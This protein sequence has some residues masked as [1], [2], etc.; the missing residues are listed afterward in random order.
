MKPTGKVGSRGVRQFGRPAIRSAVPVSHSVARIPHLASPILRLAS[1]ILPLRT[2]NRTLLAFLL[3]LS[4]LPACRT[5]RPP[6]YPR[7]VPSATRAEAALPASMIRVG[8]VETADPVEVQCPRGCTVRQGPSEIRRLANGGTLRVVPILQDSNGAPSGVWVQVAALQDPS[9][10]EALRD[11]LRQ[12]FPD[13]PA[14]HVQAFQDRR[15]V[16]AGPWADEAAA[17]AFLRRLQAAGYEA[18]LD[19]GNAESGRPTPSAFQL[20]V[21]SWVTTVPADRPL[22]VIADS[23]LTWRGQRYPGTLRV[24]ALPDG[25]VALVNVLPLELYLVGVLVQELNPQKFPALEA[26]KAQAVAARTYAVRNRN[27]Y[28][29][30]GYDICA[31]PACQAYAGVPEP[32]QA[33][34]AYTAVAETRGEVLT[35]GGEP[36]QAFYTSTCGGHTDSAEFIFPRFAA[37]YLQGVPCPDD[38]GAAAQTVEGAPMADLWASPS[39]ARGFV[40]WVHEARIW[41]VDGTLPETDRWDRWAGVW[42]DFLR[43]GLSGG[44]A[45]ASAGANPSHRN[46]PPLKPPPTRRQLLQALGRQ[47]QDPR[48][49]DLLL[50]DDT[51][52]LDRLAQGLRGDLDG[53]FRRGLLWLLLMAPDLAARWLDGGVDWPRPVRFDEWLYV[54]GRWRSAQAPPDVSEAV[55]LGVEAG[56]LRLQDP[57]GRL[58]DVAWGPFTVVLQ[59]WGDTWVGGWALL[60]PGDRVQVVLH[61]DHLDYV[62]SS[63][64]TGW[65][66][67]ADRNSPYAWW[68]VELDG[69]EVGRRL[70]SV[71]PSWEGNLRQVVPL[72]TTPYGRVVHL[73]FG[74]STGQTCEL[75]GLSVRTVLGLRELR[76]RMWPVP[77]PDGDIRRVVIVGRGWGHGVGLCQT[78]AFG[79]A[80]RGLDYR[81]ILQ[82]YYPG[83]RVERWDKE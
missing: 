40:S 64:P 16:R 12:Q 41:P 75:R 22:E 50:P 74:S 31:T 73:R 28:A 77:G 83:T 39:V 15:R 48:W 30:R 18:W 17:R 60:G 32:E 51:R 78:G 71:C 13:V 11:R 57:G 26:L 23:A 46:D 1:R 59:R 27:G 45:S 24:V 49:D 67:T 38:V 82:H 69:P 8:L 72:E 37:P 47:L 63:R 65:V 9:Q 61:G 70:R 80:L 79:M 36:I 2:R 81:A 55:V 4:F 33:S 53:D 19:R 6:G 42:A 20:V 44:T 29:H 10:A 14:W 68:T 34:L 62:E 21:G 25:R 58:W 66:G 35:Y 7:T 56:R 3:F 52:V 76:F 5:A 54:Y 43:P